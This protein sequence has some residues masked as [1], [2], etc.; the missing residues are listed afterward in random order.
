MRRIVQIVICLVFLFV[1]SMTFAAGTCLE[2]P[3]TTVRDVNQQVFD[4][5]KYT[6]TW[7]ADASGVVSGEG[8]TKVSGIIIGVQF[9]WV[10]ATDQYDVVLVE[11]GGSADVLEGVGANLSQA[12]TNRTPLTTDERFVPLIDS[13]LTPG[14]T[15]AGNGATG[16]IILYVLK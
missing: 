1:S 15:N 14:V 13:T 5:V 10:D 6:W 2:A 12:T 11:T 16:S 9:V 7:T 3:K 4:V 8:A